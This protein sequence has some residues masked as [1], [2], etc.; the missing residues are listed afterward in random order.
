MPPS[1]FQSLLMFTPADTPLH[2]TLHVFVDQSE[3]MFPH[4]R[5]F[6]IDLKVLSGQCPNKQW[7]VKV[8]DAAFPCARDYCELC[9][10]LH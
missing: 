4:W 2:H 10:R 5:S 7:T 8:G 9:F 1:G 3:K 6:E